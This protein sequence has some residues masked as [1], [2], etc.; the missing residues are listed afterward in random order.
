M[1][2]HTT[3]LVQITSEISTTI[4]RDISFEDYTIKPEKQM[5]VVSKDAGAGLVN[6]VPT[7]H[8]VKCTIKKGIQYIPEDVLEWESFI[9]LVKLGKVGIIDNSRISGSEAKMILKQS[10]SNKRQHKQSDLRVSVD[11]VPTQD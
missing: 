5:V 9:R 8:N 1:A 6:V 3:G 11:G 10:K 2:S 7:W 4:F